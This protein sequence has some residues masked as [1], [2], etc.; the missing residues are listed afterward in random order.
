MEGNLVMPGGILFHGDW[1]R[2]ERS[3]RQVAHRPE[4]GHS[5]VYVEIGIHDGRTSRDL[6][7][8]IDEETHG[9][10][11]YGIDPGLKL[12][13]TH[14]HFRYLNY[15]SHEAFRVFEP[16]EVHWVFVDGC[17][18]AACVA[19]DAIL[20]GNLLVVGGL[21][22]FHDASPGTQGLDTQ[23]YELMRGYHDEVKA[24]GGIDV[25]RFLDQGLLA[26][27]EMVEP[28]FDQ[29]RG[30]IEVYRRISK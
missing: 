11:Y 4:F 10:V 29:G 1:E 21:L 15:R 6:I 18:C 7:R 12:A 5:L 9:F 25:R 20:Y 24:K 22:L 13:W 28:A 14:D 2:L 30:G 8:C 17:H 19:R 3:V 26:G 23:D 27:F 16:K